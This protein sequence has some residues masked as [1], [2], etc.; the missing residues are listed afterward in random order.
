MNEHFIVPLL[1]FIVITLAI[2]SNDIHKILL[3]LS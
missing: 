1:V 2:I 3:I